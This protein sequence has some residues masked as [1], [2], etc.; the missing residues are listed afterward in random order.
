M[1]MHCAKSKIM[2]NLN[3]DKSLLIVGHGDKTKALTFVCLQVSDHLHKIMS[4]SSLKGKF[5]TNKDINCI[6]HLDVLH[7]PKRSKELPENVLLRLRGEIV[8][9]DA[10]P[11]ITQI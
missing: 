1:Y 9:K 3:G 10:P 6:C 8:H 5:K 2:S 4:K 7:C 11:K